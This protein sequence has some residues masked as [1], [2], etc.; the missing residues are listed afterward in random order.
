MLSCNFWI[1]RRERRRTKTKWKF[2]QEFRLQLK[3]SDLLTAQYP[4]KWCDE[5]FSFGIL[6]MHTEKLFRNHLQMNEIDKCQNHSARSQR[7]AIYQLKV[8]AAQQCCVLMFQFFVLDHFRP[9]TNTKSIFSFNS[10]NP[11]TWAKH[12]SAESIAFAYKWNVCCFE[13][14][15]FYY[16][17]LLPI[18]LVCACLRICVLCIASLASNNCHIVASHIG[19]NRKS[20]MS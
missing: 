16:V 3:V 18:P 20:I 19:R 2:V 14:I 6:A 13:S 12:Q 11:M 15:A 9:H 17:V 10:I 8:T 4:P 1:F 7:H 5:T